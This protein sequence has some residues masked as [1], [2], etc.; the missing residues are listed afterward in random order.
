MAKPMMS[1][2]FF[3]CTGNYYRSRFAEILF[4]FHAAHQKL[5]WRAESRGLALNPRNLGQMSEFTIRRLI[6]LQIPV[7]QYLR[8]PKDLSL[9]DLNAANHIVAVKESEHWP[10]ISRRFPDWLKKVEFW[11]VHDIDCAGTE[12]ALP[13]LEKQVIELM[14][15]LK[16]FPVVP[17]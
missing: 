16:D 12:V 6:R 4:N 5:L 7:D 15:R 13:Q 14:Q 17:S 3:L 10:L 1:T 9:A 11:E 2:V 8:D